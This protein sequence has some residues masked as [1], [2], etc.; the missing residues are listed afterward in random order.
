MLYQ[1]D[2][3]YGEIQKR[4]ILLKNAEEE[5]IDLNKNIS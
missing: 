5:N 3:N 1:N 4:T 2:S